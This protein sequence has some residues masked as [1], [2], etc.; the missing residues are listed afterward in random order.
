MNKFKYFL[1][2]F[3]PLLIFSQDK[4]NIDIKE[5]R[6]NMQ[7]WKIAFISDKLKFSPEQAQIFWP[8]YN[9]YS[10]EVDEVRDSAKSIMRNYKK[11][12]SLM[13]ETELGS[14][15]DNKLK[16]DQL[17]LELKIKY[18]KDFNEIISNSQLIELYNAEEGFK[19][20]VLREIRK[21]GKRKYYDPPPPPINN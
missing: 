4:N 16:T 3:L 5:K 14:M 2:F 9:K 8:V 1:I 11:N 6:R 18:V 7:A 20:E 13:S 19:R 21:G 10:S 17:Y 15:I 12:K